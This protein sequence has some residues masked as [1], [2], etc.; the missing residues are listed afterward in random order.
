MFFA[1]LPPGILVV[2][3]EDVVVQCLNTKSKVA[4]AFQVPPVS[5][6][7]YV[8]VAM[9]Y[10]YPA[11]STSQGP[12]E[13]GIVATQHDSTVD[14]LLHSPTT[15]TVPFAGMSY[16]NGDIITISL[17]QFETVQVILQ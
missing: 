15:V 8:H 17:Q 14:V 2:S 9:M 11:S 5:H 3:T 13:I 12:Y 16:T 1:V 4:D 10:K 6:L 7:G